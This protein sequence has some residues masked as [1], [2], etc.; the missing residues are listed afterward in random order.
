MEAPLRAAVAGCG[1][2]GPGGAPAFPARARRAEAL[3][4]IGLTPVGTAGRVSAS[5]A[6]EEEPSKENQR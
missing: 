1:V 5:P 4:G 6:V 2:S 3:A